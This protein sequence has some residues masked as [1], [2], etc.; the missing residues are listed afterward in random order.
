MTWSVRLRSVAVLLLACSA[1]PA[2][3][4][5]SGDK[6]KRAASRVEL[7]K[8]CALDYLGAFVA[9][10]GFKGRSR[11]RLG[12]FVGTIAGQPEDQQ[13][14]VS[15]PS[16]DDA[17]PAKQRVVEDYEP[18]AHPVETVNGRPVLAD[19]VDAITSVVEEHQTVL[20][21]P[22]AVATDAS[23]RV[24]VADPPAH[25]V[26]VLD[27]KGKTSFRIQGGKDR[28]LQTPAGVAADG[29]GNV[30]VSDSDRG[31]ILVYDHLGRF[32]HYLGK[33]KGEAYFERPAGIA[34]DGPSGRIYVA[35]TAR[36]SVFVLD[37]RGAVVGSFDARRQSSAKAEFNKPTSVVFASGQLFVLDS[38]GSRVQV[39]DGQGNLLRQVTTPND[40]HSPPDHTGLAIDGA[41][42]LYV[43][44]EVE[45]KVRVYSQE[46]K[47]V[48]VFGRPGSKT[49]EFGR[50]LGLWADARDRIYVADS[51]NRR[52][53][54]FQFRRREERGGCQ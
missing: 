12:E 38:F 33:I 40:N 3:A 16:S 15:G 19:M 30:Y 34:V 22:R 46:G 36:N 20:E 44:D 17:A 32:R 25:A 21:A 52:I 42:N 4:Q 29:L 39:L 28:R 11:L 5:D 41:G 31:M 24:V 37:L 6:A 9:D 13:A 27:F 47:L 43:S 48:G 51:N 54:V 45:G 23:G 2:R 14:G 26:H 35:D 50:P 49:G 18:G 10:G 8:T 1:V 7:G 53:Q